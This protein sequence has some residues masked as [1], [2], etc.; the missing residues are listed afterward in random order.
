M[1]NWN[2]ALTSIWIHNTHATLSVVCWS[3][4]YIYLVHIGNFSVF[5]VLWG[6]ITLNK[7]YNLNLLFSQTEIGG[8]SYILIEFK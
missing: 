8:T 7:E 2:L 4:R 3:A 5:V 6:V 1:Y